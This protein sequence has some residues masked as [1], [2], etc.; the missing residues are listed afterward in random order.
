MST[1]DQQAHRTDPR[2]LAHDLT[3]PSANLRLYAGAL[4]DTLP[5]LLAATN[6]A[7]LRR[8]TPLAGLLP[9]IPTRLGAIADT[10]DQ[11]ALRAL[12]L[13]DDTPV[14]A[15]ERDAAAFGPA[16]IGTTAPNPAPSPA[17]SVLLVEDDANS[18]ELSELMLQWE[19][20]A[21]TTTGDGGPALAL[22]EREPFDLVL[23]DCRMPELDGWTATARMRAGGP[24][25][26]TPVIGLT[27]SPDDADRVRGLA[28]GMD[29]WIV[30]PL[31]VEH[32]ADLRSR[33]HA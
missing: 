26:H 4:A 1:P 33:I 31:T 11:L 29:D 6:A 12:T 16:P 28:A 17:P 23:M 3:A 27:S 25:R 10:I 5:G 21:V 22:L 30:K 15:A 18:R 7:D 9:D 24:N 20:W 14:A 19:G 2:E 32:L 13:S 8:A